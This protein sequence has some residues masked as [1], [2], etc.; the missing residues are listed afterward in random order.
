MTRQ[1]L[2]ALAVASLTAV[3]VIG[4]AH[5]GRRTQGDPPQKHFDFKEPKVQKGDIAVIETNLGTIKFEF[6][7]DKAPKHAANFEK[8][9]EAGFYDGTAFHRVVPGFMIQGGDP[10]TR[11]K[12]ESTY[13]MGDPG[14]KLD[15]EFNDTPFERGIV[16]MA[17]AQDPNSAGSQFYIMVA[18]A[19]FLNN[20]Y[21]AFGKVTEG[22]DIAD[23]IVMV[24]NVGRP[25][26]RVVDI[27]SARVKSIKIFHPKVS[28]S[29]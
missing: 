13:G 17:R 25:T 27:N 6:L 19:P 29:K 2:T 18:P 9:A 23:K 1:L 10:N 5:S 14:W 21:T 15:A 12:D 26:N 24:P 3:V 7:L 11:G 22:M 8:L 20:Q 16:G 28:E 4:A